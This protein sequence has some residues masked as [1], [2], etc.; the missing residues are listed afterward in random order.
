MPGIRP[1][2]YGGH[3]YVIVNPSGNGVYTCDGWLDSRSAAIALGGNLITINDA[4]E[5]A[6]AQSLVSFNVPAHR[7]ADAWI[8]LNDYST[9]G[10]F[11]W[12]DGTPV[13]YTNWSSGE[14]NDWYFGNPGEDAVHLDG[15]GGWNDH[16]TIPAVGIVEIVPEPTTTTF[17]LLAALGLLARRRRD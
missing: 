16:N 2:S 7:G 11:V 8:G 4:A 14:P 12:A 15:A 10:T 3:T 1:T 6:F 13:G 9:E 17:V 5:Q